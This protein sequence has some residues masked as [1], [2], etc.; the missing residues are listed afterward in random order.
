MNPYHEKA[1]E[2]QH[3]LNALFAP[4][5]SFLCEVKHQM[6]INHLPPISISP[7]IGKFLALLAGLVNAKRILEIG[8]LGGY[9]A[10][11]M[12][13]TLPENGELISIEINPKNAEVARK[14]LKDAGLESK[15]DIK[16]GNALRIIEEIS[17]PFDLIFLDGDKPNYPNYLEPMIRLCRP[18]GL[19]LA[20][21]L[22]R[23]GKA[24]NPSPTDEQANAIATFNRLIASH[25]K[26]ESVIIPTLVGYIGGDLDGLSISRVKS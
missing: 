23:R 15:V 9:S 7:F 25:P 6:E 5:D 19:I 3:Y 8:T 17:D 20:D 2:I 10:I 18:G 24:V 14:N 16:V 22:I 21:N 26:L 4:E 11:W 1:K 13:R 12:G